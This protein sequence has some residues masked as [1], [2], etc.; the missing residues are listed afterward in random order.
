MNKI[1]LGGILIYQGH[2][3]MGD[4]SLEFAESGK[5]AHAGRI[6]VIT[7]HIHFFLIITC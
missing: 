3:S 2:Y 1:C 5:P 6:T 7:P 4:I